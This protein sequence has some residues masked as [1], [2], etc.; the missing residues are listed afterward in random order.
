MKKN[1]LLIRKATEGD[2]NRVWLLWKQIMDQKVFFP[3]DDSYSREDIERIWVNLINPCFVGEWEGKIVGAYILQPNQP[4]Y[5]N[6]IANA[7]YMVDTSI[8]GKGIGTQLCAHSIIAAKELGYYGLQ[9]NLV[10][11][12]NTSAIKAWLANGFEIIGTVPGGFRH[13]DKGYVDAYIF[14]KKL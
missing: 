14:F 10:V 4:G 3:Y 9:F 2:L 1:N 13:I 7:A 6:H 5:G 8:R 12:T 11:S